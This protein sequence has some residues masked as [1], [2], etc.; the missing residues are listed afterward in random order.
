MNASS[1]A[2]LVFPSSILPFGGLLLTATVSLQNRSAFRTW[3]E[4]RRLLSQQPRRSLQEQRNMPVAILS[5]AAESDSLL[6]QCNAN[7]QAYVAG[8]RTAWQGSANSRHRHPLLPPATLSSTHSSNCA[9][10]W[11]PCSSDRLRSQGPPKVISL[12]THRKNK[13]PSRR[14]RPSLPVTP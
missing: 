5:W 10:F 1:V 12:R 7:A 2:Q 14:K 9:S 3:M 4:S 11:M 8:G 13:E 6:L